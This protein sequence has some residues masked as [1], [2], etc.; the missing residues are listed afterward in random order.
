MIQPHRRQSNSS[1]THGGTVTF[2]PEPVASDGTLTFTVVDHSDSSI[3]GEIQV[4]GRNLHYVGP[5]GADENPGTKQ[6]SLDSI[7][8]ALKRAK[9]GDTTQAQPGRYT[10]RGGVQTVRVG[11]AENPITITGPLDAVF[12]AD[13]PFE[14]N[15][16]H[17]HIRGLSFDGLHRPGSP[18]DP[19]SYSESILQIN[20]SF[21]ERINSGAHSPESVS[22]ENYLRDIV[23]KPHTVGNCRADFIK[24]HWSK[25]VEIGEFKVIGLAGM[26]YLKG[27]ATGHN[28][29]V[30]YFGNAADKS[31]PVD[32]THDI[33][34]HHIDNS[35]GH[36]R[37]ELV[38]AKSGCYNVLIKYCTDAGGA[39]RYLLEGH[40]L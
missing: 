29:E 2:T 40:D 16:N 17:V 38:D 7:Q 39:G 14:I 18:D 8:Y 9:P 3:Q 4:T 27:D 6:S 36:P 23:V 20:E 11:T 13:G 1:Q 33:H 26:K 21:F 35:E 31:Y 37:T 10:P 25:N 15:H 22:E 28:G 24:V 12:N 5:E 30:V 32:A 34:I 19:D